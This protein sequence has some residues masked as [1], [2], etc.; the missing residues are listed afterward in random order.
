MNESGSGLTLSELSRLAGVSPRTTR[1]YIQQGLLPSPGS[2]RGTKYDRSHL[3]RI[4]LIKAL[5]EHHLPLADIRERLQNLSDEEV[6]EALE[7]GPR[8]KVER[9]SAMDYVRSVL[10]SQEPHSRSYL[11]RALSR[12]AHRSTDHLLRST[13]EHYSLTPD[14]EI[15]VRRPLSSEQNRKLAR[16]VELARSIFE[17]DAK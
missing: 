14:I 8:R 1:Y 11:S 17:E 15:H 16:L 9:E 13:W 5:Q 4:K 10:S 3:E 7:E 6:H 12:S 2:G